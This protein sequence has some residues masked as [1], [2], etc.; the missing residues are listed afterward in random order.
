MGLEVGW[1]QRRC[2]SEDSFILIT[3]YTE[4]RY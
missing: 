2:D 1:L 3:A 4:A